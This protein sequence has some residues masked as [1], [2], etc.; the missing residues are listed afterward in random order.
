MPFK[1]SAKFTAAK[2]LLSSIKGKRS[3]LIKD[4]EM[5]YQFMDEHRYSWNVRG[6]Q[7]VKRSKQ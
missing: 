7:W 4:S 1:P 5:L 2:A 3:A 6:G